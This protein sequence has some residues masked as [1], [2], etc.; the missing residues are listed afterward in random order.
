MIKTV[1]TE[2]WWCTYPI[3]NAPMTPAAT[4][5]L[6]R[7][8][9]E[10]GGFG[11]IGVNETWT[12]DD[13]RGECEIARENDSSLRFGIGFVGWVLEQNPGLL[14][15]AIEL[16]PFLISI[17]FI[18]VAPYARKVHDAGILLAAQVQT[19][20]DAEAALHGGVDVLVAQGTEAGGHTGDVSTLT[21][22]Q[23]ALATSDK[24]VIAAGGIATSQG[25]AAVLAAGAAG[26][27][28]GTPF[29][30]AKEANVADAARERIMA[31]AETDTVLTA[32][33]DRVQGFPWPERF[34]GRVLRNHLT[35]EW[36]GREAAAC[37]D[38]WVPSALQ[39]AKA[40]NDFRIAN[41]YAGQS[42]GLI[43]GPCSAAEL[44]QGLGDGAER[45]LRER[46]ARLL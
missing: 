31:S 20:R 19:R 16:K 17:S 18:D 13:I 25:L 38:S 1:L 7:T 11:M 14:D 6:A 34:K 33:F 23:I 10:A 5:V 30:L 44:V 32:L 39:A 29:L 24:P 45:I 22:L 2:T 4:G 8:V 9:S 15:V 36:H 3:V 28:I 43:S 41:V 21:I 42:V 37:S 40:N 35:D 27:W 46:F 26:A 12:A